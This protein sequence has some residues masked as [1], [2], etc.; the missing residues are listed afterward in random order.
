MM[1]IRNSS[2]IRCVFPQA[3]FSC[4]AVLAI[5]FAAA[6]LFP[7]MPNIKKKYRKKEIQ[8][9]KMDGRNA[10][11]GRSRKFEA[12]L[13]DRIRTTFPSYSLQFSLFPTL[14][15]LSLSPFLRLSLPLCPFL[16]FI[17]RALYLPRMCIV[18]IVCLH[19]RNR[20]YF[21]FVDYVATVR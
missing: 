18:S 2:F 5:P 15:L 12:T 13:F 20:F 4:F 8:C 11:N 9:N 21:R 7:E 16:R 10:I 19:N 17:S 3:L 6:C 1:T 14:S